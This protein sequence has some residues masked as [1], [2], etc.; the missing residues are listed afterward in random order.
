M[1]ILIVLSSQCFSARME[2]L[3]SVQMKYHDTSWSE[4]AKILDGFVAAT[5]YDSK[6]A[7]R[8][9]HDPETPVFTRQRRAP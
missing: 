2:L 9:L 5:D 4:K 3:R 6:Y 8:L 1:T 7:I